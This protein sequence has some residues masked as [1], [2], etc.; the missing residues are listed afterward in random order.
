VRTRRVSRGPFTSFGSLGVKEPDGHQ[1]RGVDLTDGVAQQVRPVNESLV[2]HLVLVLGIGHVVGL[3]VGGGDQARG[4]G[5][6]GVVLVEVVLLAQLVGPDVV[7]GGMAIDE[8]LD[9]R[10]PLVDVDRNGLRVE[11]LVVGAVELL[12]GQ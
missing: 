9:H 11:E 10:L 8:G 4:Q 1:G 12:V 5:Q 6:R 7:E 3:A 2:D